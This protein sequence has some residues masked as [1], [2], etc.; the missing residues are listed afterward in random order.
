[1][2]EC[3]DKT[4]LVRLDNGLE[5]GVHVEAAQDGADVISDRVRCEAELLGHLLRG[6]AACKKMEDLR[7]PRRERNRSVPCARSGCLLINLYEPEYASDAL[8]AANGN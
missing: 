1:M 6:A 3:S 4:T 7:L 5:T 8:A 2:S